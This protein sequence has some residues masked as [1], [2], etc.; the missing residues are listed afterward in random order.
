MVSRT[1]VEDAVRNVVQGPERGDLLFFVGEQTDEQLSQWRILDTDGDSAIVAFVRRKAQGAVAG[2]GMTRTGDAG[3]AAGLGVGSA[4]GAGTAAGEDAVGVSTG[5]HNQAALIPDT[6]GAY[7]RRV[8]AAQ[9]LDSGSTSVDNGGLLGMRHRQFYLDQPLG[10]LLPVSSAAQEAIL[11][12]SDLLKYVAVEPDGGSVRTFGQMVTHALM[13][14]HD[15]QLASSETATSFK[16]QLLVGIPLSYALG[17]LGLHFRIDRNAADPSGDTTK[18]LRPDFLCWIRNAL[19]LKGEEKANESALQEANRELTSKMA[20]SWRPGL[21]PGVSMPCMMAYT[22]AGNLMQFFAIT[23]SGGGGVE[24]W[25]ISELLDISRPLGRIKVVH[26]TLHIARLLAAYAPL[27]PPQLSIALGGMIQSKGLGGRLL[28]NVMLF[29]DFVQKR[30]FEYLRQPGVVLD[31]ST[32][33]ELYTATGRELCANLVRL[34][35]GAIRMEGTTLVLHLEP[36]GLPL[37]A[38]PADEATLKEAIRGVLLGIAALHR[39]GFVHRDVRWRNVIRVPELRSSGSLSTYVL[40]DLEHAARADCAVDC[41]EPDFRL[42]SWPSEDMLESGSGR[43]TP[44]SDLCLVAYL[45]MCI[46]LSQ[47][48]QRLQQALAAR[49]VPSAEA[50]L[51]HEWLSLHAA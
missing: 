44:A 11:H 9:F 30:A 4:A 16:T 7:F 18:R 46:P 13:G 33:V 22:A 43:Y 37:D 29:G 42:G 32:L 24:A 45:M 17:R 40:I 39:A 20:T 15:V 3:A 34:H 10:A 5:Q 28:G 27:A 1:A 49:Q 48:G 21:L 38:P 50:A 25:P 2:V 23:E 47:S 12:D 31:F 36:V 14:W 41:R 26:H 51:Q 8:M 35:Q 19:L 6:S